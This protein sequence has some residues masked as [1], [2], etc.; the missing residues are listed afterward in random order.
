LAYAVNRAQ[1]RFPGGFFVRVG[2]ASSIMGYALL[3]LVA[4]FPP[5]LAVTI[6]MV[7]LGA[8]LFLVAFKILG[9]IDA[10]DKDR[11]RSLRL[12]GVNLALR[13]L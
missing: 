8:G 3:P 4:F 9:G 13:L 10:V 2:V 6:A 11:F 1:L 12:P 7:G 5:S